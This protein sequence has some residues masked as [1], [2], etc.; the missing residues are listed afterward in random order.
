MTFY[1]LY[2]KGETGKKYSKTKTW[3]NSKFNQNQSKESSAEP[4]SSGDKGQEKKVYHSR[5]FR[6][7]N[8]DGKPPGKPQKQP[9]KNEPNEETKKSGKSYASKRR[10]R[11]QQKAKTQPNSEDGILD[12]P[13]D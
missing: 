5:E 3:R 10:E 4:P 1:L 2:F 12:L 9:Q 11:Q 13:S 7:T 8:S 6:R